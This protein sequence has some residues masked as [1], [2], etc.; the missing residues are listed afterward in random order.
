MGEADWRRTS[1]TRQRVEARPAARAHQVA[2]VVL[3]AAIVLSVL[4]VP[5][6]ALAQASSAN[7]DQAGSEALTA[8]LKQNRLPLVGA[9]VMNGSGGTR[10]VVL[11]GFVATDEGKHDAERKVVAYLGTPVPSIDDRLVIKP[12]LA[13][14][15]A[16]P[17]ADQGADSP[18]S[19]NGAPAG[20]MTFGELY[21]QIQQYGIK[22]P[23]GE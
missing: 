3:A 11:Y 19:A 10:R 22:N 1:L 9:Q 20:G 5:R 21:Q 23:P 6:L 17:S 12:E 15:T 14:M 4:A 18:A 8:Y 7:V 16:P 13:T 2:L